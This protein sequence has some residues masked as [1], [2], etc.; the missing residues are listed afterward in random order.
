MLI[1]GLVLLG[2]NM[3]AVGSGLLGFSLIHGSMNL[4]MA[5]V[6]TGTG[7][8]ALVSLPVALGAVR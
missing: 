8:M 6:A 5:M 4:F 1:L 7:A 2:A 3:G